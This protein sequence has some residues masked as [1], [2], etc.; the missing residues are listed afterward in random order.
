MT[1]AL[2]LGSENPQPKSKEFKI[3]RELSSLT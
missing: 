2:E 1:G 3:V